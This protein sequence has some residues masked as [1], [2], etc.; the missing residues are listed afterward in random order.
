MSHFGH[1]GPFTETVLLGNLALR[2]GKPIDW[3][4]MRMIA[5]GCP[6]A[7][8]LIRREYRPGFSI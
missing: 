7:D 1:A 5:R 4:S 6:D 2:V 8:P 3:D